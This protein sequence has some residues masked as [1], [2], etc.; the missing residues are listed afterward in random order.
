MEEEARHTKEAT[1]REIERVLKLLNESQLFDP[2]LNPTE[3]TKPKIDVFLRALNEGL[4]LE[5]QGGYTIPLRL[6]VPAKRAKIL[7]LEEQFSRVELL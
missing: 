5:S 7:D 2:P 4:L 1:Q 3:C 6:G